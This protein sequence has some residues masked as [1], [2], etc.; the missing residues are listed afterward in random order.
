MKVKKYRLQYTEEDKSFVNKMISETLDRGYLTD[1]GPNIDRFE[2]MWSE[3]NGS[4]YSIAISN[5]TTGLECILRALDVKGHS[6]IVPSY[7]FIA[8]PMSIFNAGATPIYADID[9]DTLSLSLETIKKSVRPDTK[10]VMIVHV[11]GVI[12]NEIIKIKEWCES[13]NIHLI[14]DAACAHG[15]D[16]KGI[17]TGNFGIAGCFSFH[18]SKVL[19][20]GEGGIITTN[21]KDLAK[22]MKRI[23]AIGLDRT[24]NN[25]ESFEVGSN[26]KMSEITAVLG[27]LHTKNANKIINERKEIARKY[28][29]KIK[30]NNLVSKFSLPKNT[31][32]CYYKY[33]LHAKDK[34]TRNKLIEYCKSKNIEMP[35]YT[36]E[37]LCSDQIISKKINCVLESDL[38]NSKWSSDHI[39]CLPMYNGLKENE[40]EYIS[41]TVNDFISQE[42]SNDN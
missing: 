42:A 19:T 24:I 41:K 5:C 39:V 3:F 7:T 2:K 12:T 1:G 17:K 8:S 9:K 30:F 28:N 36:Y 38:K 22:K 26:F 33:Y 37:V 16:Y 21:N 40:I 6:V 14:E 11:G 34:D 29:N 35:P 23:R 13:K 20:S 15:S 31:D 32:S 27:I 18:H 10:A 4:D 25:Y